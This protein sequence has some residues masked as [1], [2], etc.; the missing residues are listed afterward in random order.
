V[1][2]VVLTEQVDTGLTGA[3]GKLLVQALLPVQDLLAKDLLADQDFE[4]LDL[5]EDSEQEVEDDANED[6]VTAP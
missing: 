2:V 5:V 3:T 4:C 6:E 1:V